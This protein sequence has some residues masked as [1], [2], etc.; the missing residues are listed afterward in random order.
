MV[1]VMRIFEILS[2]EASTPLDNNQGSATAP[3]ATPDMG[4][5]STP[6]QPPMQQANML[7]DF[8]SS[9]RPIGGSTPSPGTP[10]PTPPQPAGTPPAQTTGMISRPFGS[11]AIGQTLDKI[12]TGLKPQ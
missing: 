4:M 12:N 6:S 3:M 11:S 8:F 5:S 10:S 1:I 9:P 7:T 2:G